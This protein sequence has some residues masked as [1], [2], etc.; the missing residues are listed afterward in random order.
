MLVRA[1]GSTFGT[2]GGGAIEKH[3][4]D[5]CI[6]DPPREPEVLDFEL[7]DDLGM[8]CG[9]N[10]SVLLEPIGRG[11]RLVLFGAGHIARELA[12]LATAAG[13]R[14]AVVDERPEY[15]TA[16]RFPDAA[17]IVHS[18]DAEDW[19]ALRLDSS[20]YCVIL[21][22]GHVHDTAIL[23]QL[24]GRELAYLGMIGSRRK[25]AAAFD[26][27]RRKGVPDEQLQEVCAP[28]GLDIGSETPFEIAVSILAQLI[29]VRRTGRP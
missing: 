15:A 17:A 23:Q 1:D 6:A 29:R 4:V 26:A 7:D 12:P 5:R 28:I 20:A 11:P 14:V 24:A 16:Q 10:M 18:F 22:H 8:R 13:F 27:L 2:I 25:V 3:V 21:T 9:G 19:E